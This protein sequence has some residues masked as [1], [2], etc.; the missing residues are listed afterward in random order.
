MSSKQSF[1]D[2]EAAM[3]EWLPW[4]YAAST[5]VSTCVATF[6]LRRLGRIV[7]HNLAW[8]FSGIPVA[9][10]QRAM[11]KASCDDLGIEMPELPPATG[12]DLIALPP[13]PAL[14]PPDEPPKAS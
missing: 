12:A 7:A 8:K 13:P 9:A 5:A 2:V 10:R 14:P 3:S 11:F 1:W 4:L 6:S